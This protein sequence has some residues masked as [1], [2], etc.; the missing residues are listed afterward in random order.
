MWQALGSAVDVTHALLM[1]AWLL[2]MP[3][4]FWHGR[5]TFTRAYAVYATAFVVVSQ[6][7]R[8]IF[9]ECVFTTLARWL[10]NHPSG[11]SRVDGIPH[12]WFTVRL[13][14]A[15]FAMAP[16]HRAI[17]VSSEILSAVAALGVLWSM[18]RLRRGRG[19]RA[20]AS[21]EIGKE[22]LAQTLR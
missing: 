19:R 4:L 5:P 12:E 10:W 3:L 15:I 14:R 9:G 8:P 21:S 20:P 6:L 1:A 16:S 7:S 17:A 13:S 22:P 18:R 2:G 11:S